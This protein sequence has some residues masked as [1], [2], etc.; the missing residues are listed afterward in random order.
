L[1]REAFRTSVG[2]A[3]AVDLVVIAKTGAAKVSASD[4]AD[5]YATALRRMGLSKS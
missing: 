4:V 3:S 2:P 5:D 1:I